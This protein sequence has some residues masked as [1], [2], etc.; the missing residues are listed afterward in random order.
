MPGIVYELRLTSLD[1][2]MARARRVSANSDAAALR[3]RRVFY[4]IGKLLLA[5][6]DQ[7]TPLFE[8][9]LVSLS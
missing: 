1:L 5:A 8:L 3:R 6:K 4:E 7:S 2:A 9:S